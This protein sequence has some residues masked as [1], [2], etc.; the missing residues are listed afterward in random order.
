MNVKQMSRKVSA[1]VK[2]RSHA[3]EQAMQ[4]TNLTCI[5]FVPFLFVPSFYENRRACERG[6]DFKLRM[7]D[8]IH[9]VYLFSIDIAIASLF[10]LVME[11]DNILIPL[12]LL[13][14]GNF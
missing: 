9:I 12:Y 10:Y 3:G 1:P 14:K 7:D 8:Q 5:L 11:I 4:T 13:I 6:P 2:R